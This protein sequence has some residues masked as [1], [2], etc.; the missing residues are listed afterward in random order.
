MAKIM[1]RVRLH[2]KQDHG[3]LKNYHC[4]LFLTKRLR[5]WKADYGLYTREELI[6]VLHSVE[7][8]CGSSKSSL[9][10]KYHR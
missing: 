7:M 1:I 3:M 6:P 10:S 5:M 2:P 4:G 8:K 9:S